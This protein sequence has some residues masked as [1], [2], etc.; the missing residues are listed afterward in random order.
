VPD[1]SLQPFDLDH[2][3]VPAWPEHLKPIGEGDGGFAKQP[4]ADWW[5]YHRQ[6]LGHLPAD[7]CEQWIHRH[8]SHSPFTFLPLDTLRCERSSWT[9]E[10]V[11]RHAFRAWGGELHPQFDYET[12]QRKGGA[13]RHQTARALDAGTWDFPIVLL[14]TPNGVID[15]G[16]VHSDVRY[17][18]VEGHQR[19]RYLNA[20]HH[21]GKPPI[22]PH[23]VLILSSPVVTQTPLSD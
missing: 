3:G 5:H 21:L 11:L 6:E 22:G 13:D 4:F 15:N 12:F 16:L 19:H 7:L 17:V 23:A 18:I 1:S 14:S 9:G 8:W 10:E 2:V 20:L